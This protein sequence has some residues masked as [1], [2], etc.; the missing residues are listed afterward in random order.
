MV[1]QEK[2]GGSTGAE[3]S[4]TKEDDK[5]MWRK[6]WKLPVK[7]KLKHFLWKCIH[8]WLSTNDAVKR[9][10]MDTDEICR[11]C[12]MDKESKEHLFFFHCADSVL[13]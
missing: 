8:G 12:R 6:V 13:I 7:P 4:H 10:G 5:R 1:Q 3:T 2:E 11:R 9:R